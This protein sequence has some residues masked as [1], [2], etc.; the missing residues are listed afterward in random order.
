[1]TVEAGHVLP[2]DLF[3]F[4]AK[5]LQFTGRE[6]PAVPRLMNIL[7]EHLPIYLQMID[8][9][10][11]GPAEAKA[12]RVFSALNSLGVL[13][14]RPMLLQS[15]AYRTP[16]VGWDYILRLVVRR[17]IVG[18]LGTGNVE[19]GFGEA[20]RKITE[21]NDWTSI[22]ADLRDLNPPKGG[23]CATAHRTIVQ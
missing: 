8:P 13:A 5:R 15:P 4:L 22:V 23:F 11:D 14:V 10:L 19:R 16:W 12:L 7:N 20:A 3:G 9:S 6:P 21:T 18:N 17:I 2:K 1:M